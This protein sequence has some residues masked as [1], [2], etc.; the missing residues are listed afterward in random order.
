M[1]DIAGQGEIDEAINNEIG[2]ADGLAHFLEDGEILLRGVV[3]RGGR[4]PS[5]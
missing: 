3:R 4:R 2:A 5:R 1:P